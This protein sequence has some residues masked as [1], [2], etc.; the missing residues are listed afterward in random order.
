MFESPAVKIR[1]HTAIEKR[2]AEGIFEHLHPDARLGI[3]DIEIIDFGEVFGRR[4][5]GLVGVFCRPRIE[6]DPDAA[7]VYR[8]IA[9]GFVAVVI[10]GVNSFIHPGKAAL[11]GGQDAVEPVVA[12]PV[13]DREVEFFGRRADIDGRDGRVFHATGGAHFRLHRGD[14]IVG[15]FSDEGGSEA[16]GLL[17]II[18]TVRPPGAG[19]GSI[20]S[21]YVDDAAGRELQGIMEGVETPICEPGEIVNIG[22]VVV[23]GPGG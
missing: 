23:K 10:I 6:I 7:I 21:V 9:E 5:D 3:G 1:V 18:G 20:E 16:D 4:G 12:D 8:G 15:I 13:F 17:D 11:V 2:C 19:S 14:N 22:L